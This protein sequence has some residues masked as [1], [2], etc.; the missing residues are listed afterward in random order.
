[1]IKGRIRA[2]EKLAPV[3]KDLVSLLQQDDTT[4]KF[5]QQNEVEFTMD[6]SFRLIIKNNTPAD[7]PIEKTDEE[8]IETEKGDQV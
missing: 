2:G 8:V 3:A 6:N 7:T 5:L 1:M 4:N